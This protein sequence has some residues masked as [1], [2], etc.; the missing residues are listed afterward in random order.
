MNELVMAE[1]NRECKQDREIPAPRMA[2]VLTVNPAPGFDREG[3]VQCRRQI[4]KEPGVYPGDYDR[5]RRRLASRLK[6]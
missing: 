6:H 3:G 1:P 4:L 2:W 5:K